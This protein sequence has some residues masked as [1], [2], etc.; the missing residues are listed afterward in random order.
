MPDTDSL[1]LVKRFTY[2]GQPEE[3]SNTYH[4]D[5][6]TPTTAAEWKTLAT[7][8][9]TSEKTLHR[10]TVVLVA[11]YGYEAGNNV[12]V[13]QIDYTTG[14]PLLPN[15]TLLAPGGDTAM[16][17][18][19]ASTLRAL[20][21]Q[22]STGKRVYVRK[23]FHGGNVQTS[24]PDLLTS[25]MLTAMNSHAT[26]MLGGTLPGG[27]KWVA[28]QGA[29]PTLPVASIYVTTRTLKRRGKRPTS[30]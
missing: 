7:A 21:G 19:Q 12:S 2:R 20:V 23:Y 16:A 28:P 27:M 6:T 18:D 15:G 29:T 22:S 5:G 25:S 4:L 24:S 17:G 10:S 26:L 3:F 11:A 30:P 8:M 9:W 14:T 13:A 1:T